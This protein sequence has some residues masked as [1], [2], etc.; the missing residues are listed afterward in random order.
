VQ[1]SDRASGVFLVALG[2]AAFWGGSRL[3]DVP[4]QD[5]GPAVFPMVIGAGLMACGAM[6][7]LGIGRSFEVPEGEV[8]EPG[9]GRLFGLRALIP[10]GLLLFYVLAAERLGFLITA[11]IMVLIGALSLRARPW[12]AITMAILAPLVIHLAFYR[13]LRVPLPPGILPAPWAEA[14]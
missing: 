2:G 4:G 12:L 10:P 14:G 11:G 7:A 5:I 3:P 6:I 8:E 13:L 1:L 9:Q